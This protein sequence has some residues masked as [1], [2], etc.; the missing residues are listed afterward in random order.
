MGREFIGGD[1]ALIIGTGDIL[2]TFKNSDRR[3]VTILE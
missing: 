1:V 2:T 3:I